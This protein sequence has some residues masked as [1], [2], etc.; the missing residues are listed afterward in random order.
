MVA[1][2]SFDP[3]VD[4]DAARSLGQIEVRQAA[5]QFFEIVRGSGNFTAVV[6]LEKR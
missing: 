4:A 5:K 1:I 6:E 2:G 3:P